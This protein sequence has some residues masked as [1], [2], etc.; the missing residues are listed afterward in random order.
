MRRRALYTRLALA[1]ALLLLTSL[2]AL[3]GTSLYSA[4]FSL[5]ELRDKLLP[6]VVGLVPF[7]LAGAGFIV[8]RLGTFRVLSVDVDNQQYIYNHRETDERIFEA[9]V[10]AVTARVWDY[11]CSIDSAQHTTR[12][13]FLPPTQPTHPP[14]PT[15]P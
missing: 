10:D 7:A 2:V 5:A 3:L 12:K 9:L 15:T 8:L 13:T 14:A 1:L 11:R 6:I 4:D